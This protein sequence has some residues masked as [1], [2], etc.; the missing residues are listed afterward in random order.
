M[1]VL[2][3]AVLAEVIRKGRF[4]ET[5]F[6]SLPNIKERE[7]IFNVHLKKV[8]PA[9]LDSYQLLMTAVKQFAPSNEF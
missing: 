1:A 2:R 8:R 3:Q 4:D 5:F 7:S 6:L 9:N